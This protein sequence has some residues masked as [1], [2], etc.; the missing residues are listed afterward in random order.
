MAVNTLKT[1]R[2]S[3]RGR[4]DI[5]ATFA[6]LPTVRT[7]NVAGDSTPAIDPPASTTA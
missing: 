3:G 7:Y 5:Q 6:P 2:R 1:G 4:G